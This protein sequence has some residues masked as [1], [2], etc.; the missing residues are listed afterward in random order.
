MIYIETH[1]ELA[2][3]VER[4]RGVPRLALDTEFVRERQYYPQLEI[5]QVATED[6]QAIID[7]RALQTLDPFTT[8]LDDPRTLKIMHAGYQDLEIFFNLTGKG[9][10]PIFDTQ[11]AAAMVG[12]GA[13]VG[14]A[15]LVESLL[16]VSLRKLETLTDWSR[17]PLSRAQLEYALDDV[18]YL[19][20]L[21]EKLAGTLEELGR[22]A[23]LEEEWAAMADP[24]NYR[25][26]HPRDAWRRVQGVNRLRP[27]ELSVLRELAEWRE[28]LGSSENRTPGHIIRDNILVEI[29]RRAPEDAT[30]LQQIRG[31]HR[32]DVD[33]YARPLLEAVRRGKA[34]PREE[35]PHLPKRASLT[36]QE[37]S[38]VNLMQAWLRARADELNIA[39]NY[40]ATASE[41][42][43][44]VSSAPRDRKES[45]VLHGWRYK[46]VGKELLD[47][48]E[49]RS[50]LI[51][52]PQKARLELVH[53]D[54][55][56]TATIHTDPQPQPG[57]Q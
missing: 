1:D 55:I 6:V 26:V 47:L 16:G 8:L 32:R 45:P 48:L 27:K 21:H 41:L 53:E 50:A 14:Y 5:L 56:H 44:L 31:M 25:R 49:G 3:L 30:G 10:S 15:R 36:D 43:D 54:A 9:S 19:L 2:Q 28:R 52:E 34:L 18:R 40:L 20:P 11:V 39:V 57:E 29:V 23:W 42:R 51:W 17:R 46:L 38:L 13:Q 22:T 12:L 33:R 7:Y 24:D 35:W 4:I 37:S